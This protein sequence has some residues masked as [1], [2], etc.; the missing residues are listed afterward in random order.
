MNMRKLS[1]SMFP[2]STREWVGLAVAMISVVVVFAV[3]ARSQSFRG[4]V[5]WYAWS[6]L[7]LSVTLHLA[8]R[9]TLLVSGRSAMPTLLDKLLFVSVQVFGLAAFVAL[10]FRK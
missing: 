3:I 4:V 9:G 2:S 7:A 5:F 1:L 10:Y 8:R 6:G